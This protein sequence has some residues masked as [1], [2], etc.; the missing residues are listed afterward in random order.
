MPVSRRVNKF[1]SIC[2]M[3]ASVLRVYLVAC[4]CISL[5]RQ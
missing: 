3:R 4:T 5:S 2:F 1:L